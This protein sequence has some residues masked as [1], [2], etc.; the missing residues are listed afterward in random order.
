[1]VRF[2]NRHMLVEFLSPAFCVPNIDDPS[3]GNPNAALPIP[4][5]DEGGADE[6][7]DDMLPVLP[8][9]PFMVPNPSLSGHLQ[10]GDDGA[11]AVFRA[12]RANVL[13]CFGDEGWGRLASS[14]KGELPLSAS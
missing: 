11:S 7:S 14:F 5:A 3:P 4:T 2:K 10:L 8:L 9:V 13:D 1:M 12:V 6:D